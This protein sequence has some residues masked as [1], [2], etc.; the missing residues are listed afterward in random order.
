MADLLDRVRAEISARVKET[1]TAVEEY[2]RLE[3]ALSAL[4][5]TDRAASRPVLAK[6]RPAPRRRNARST[7]R[8]RAP[9]GANRTA[10][11][12]AVSERPG[13]SAAEL[14]AASGVEKNVLYGVLR[15]LA[16]QGEVSRI[17]LPGGGN[18]YRLAAADEVSHGVNSRRRTKTATR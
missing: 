2:E 10:V 13:A 11:L 9:R 7:A 18:G 5:G 14:S 3:Q 1:R 4:D 15:T 16:Q 17:Q 8:K 6:T 12:A